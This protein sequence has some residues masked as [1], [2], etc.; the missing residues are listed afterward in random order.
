MVGLWNTVLSDTTTFQN[1]SILQK[2]WAKY[3]F[4]ILSSD[5]SKKNEDK[6]DDLFFALLHEWYETAFAPPKSTIIKHLKYE[7]KCSQV[8]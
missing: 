3:I 4:F 6:A 1:I 2:T 5:N 8:Q 7:G